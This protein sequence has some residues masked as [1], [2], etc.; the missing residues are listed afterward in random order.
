MDPSS[1]DGGQLPLIKQT[2][3]PRS[4]ERGA[5]LI[6]V[7]LA[8]SGSNRNIGIE[9]FCF[10]FGKCC[11]MVLEGCYVVYR[12]SVM[13]YSFMITPKYFGVVFPQCFDLSY[14]HFMFIPDCVLD[15]LTQLSQFNL[16]CRC[17]F[18]L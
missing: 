2:T 18:F 17:L 11:C 7:D 4:A 8:G 3:K 1:K 5:L 14:I 15:F 16:S 12:G 10:F 6:S 13:K 9:K